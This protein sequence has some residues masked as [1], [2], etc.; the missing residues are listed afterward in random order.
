MCKNAAA[1]VESYVCLFARKWIYNRD[2]YTSNILT[3]LFDILER[4]RG[5]F[6]CG[7]VL[8]DGKVS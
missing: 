4:R 2:V 1:I 5:K 6:A 3:Y 8:V 7:T